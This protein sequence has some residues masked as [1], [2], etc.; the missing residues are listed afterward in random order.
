MRVEALA[1]EHDSA[2][3]AYRDLA[4][5][6]RFQGT[7]PTS[8]QHVR[9]RAQAQEGQL[10]LASPGWF[11]LVILVDGRVV[12]DLG[13]HAIDADQVEIGI[14]LAPDIQG[15]GYAI[16]TLRLVLDAVLQ[17][18]HRLIASVD[19]RNIP[20]MNLMARVGMRQ[21]AHHRQSI[22]TPQGW[23]DDVIFAMLASELRPAA[24]P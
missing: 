16:E 3:F 7:F 10:P 8:V 9:E 11:Q 20:C 21:E 14:T 19:P 6:R 22:H 18:R 24:D 15:R 1:C 23:T 4:E 5:V 2:V 13:L 12:G 17:I